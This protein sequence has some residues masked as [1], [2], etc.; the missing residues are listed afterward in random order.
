MSKE[1]RATLYVFA[2]AVL[3]SIGGLCVKVIPWSG[4]TINGVRSLISVLILLVY[5]KI[6][7]HKFVFNKSVALG[8]VSMAGTTTLYCLAY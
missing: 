3:F 2:S 6:T 7:G 4:I 5:F 8:A 1:K